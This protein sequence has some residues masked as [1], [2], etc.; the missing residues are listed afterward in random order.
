[1]AFNRP[2]YRKGGFVEFTVDANIYKIKRDPDLR[3][4]FFSKVIEIG[5]TEG[6][7]LG[8][9]N[10]QFYDWRGDPLR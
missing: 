4:L 6:V 2:L 1:M 9:A 3:N 7:Y 5:F 8:Y 10:A